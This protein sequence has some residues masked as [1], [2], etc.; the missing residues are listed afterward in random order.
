MPLVSVPILLPA[1]DDHTTL[2]LNVAFVIGADGALAHIASS[3]VTTIQPS[4]T[5]WDDETKS[6]PS[7][8]ILMTE[9]FWWFDLRHYESRAL[10]HSSPVVV[11]QRRPAQSHVRLVR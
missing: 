2:R 6:I 7:F 10:H 1:Q 3:H 8:S 9:A 5:E 4:T 11:A